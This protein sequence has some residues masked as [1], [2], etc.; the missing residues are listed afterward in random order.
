VYKLQS[1]NYN[2]FIED[3]Q[4]PFFQG[5]NKWSPTYRRRWRKSRRGAVEVSTNPRL[6]ANLPKG[7][8]RRRR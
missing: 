6:V 4:Q 3:K 1:S 8:N 7:R 5:Q 2:I